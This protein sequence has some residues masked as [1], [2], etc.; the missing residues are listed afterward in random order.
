[1]GGASVTTVTAAVSNAIIVIISS[2]AIVAAVTIAGSIIIVSSVNVAA[3]INIPADVIIVAATVAVVITD[4]FA[5]VNIIIFDI[6]STVDYLI[7]SV[8][9]DNRLLFQVTEGHSFKEQAVRVLC[10][11]YCVQLLVSANAT[12][13]FGLVNM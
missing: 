3:H 4:I 8:P 11:Y 13:V 12:I 5:V 7:I 2:D 1:M 6:V 10:K 9:I